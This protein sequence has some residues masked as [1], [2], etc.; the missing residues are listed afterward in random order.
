MKKYVTSLAAG[1]IV[2]SGIG[3][4]MADTIIVKPED[5]KVYREYV[6]KNP[7]ASIKLP[8][9]ELNVGTKLNDQVELREVPNEKY[10]YTVIEGRT[11][12]VDPDTREVVQVLDGN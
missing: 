4:A 12:L 1:A 2:M 9:V 8:G 5:Q 10:R 7:L 3:V 11:V 6:H